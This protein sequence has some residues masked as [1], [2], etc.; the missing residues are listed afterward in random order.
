MSA[1][2]EEALAILKQIPQGVDIKSVESDGNDNATFTNWTDTSHSA[3]MKSWQANKKGP[4]LWTACGGFAANFA[5]RLGIT[6]IASIFELEQSL[7][8]LDKAY[9]WVSASSGAK[10]QVGDILRHT[11]YHVD[12]AAGW[13]GDALLRVAAGQSHHKRP[14]EDPSAEFDVL[15]WVG[16][17]S[18]YV[19]A[20]FR[21]WLDLDLYFAGAP[22]AEGWLRGWW[23]VKEDWNGNTYYYY[24]GADNVVKYTETKPAANSGPPKTAKNTGRY[25]YTEPKQLVLTWKTV[26]GAEAACRETFYN[27]APACRLMNAVSNLYGPLVATRLS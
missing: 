13:K 19:A 7:K 1:K 16:G 22:G 9:A 21:G 20:N 5:K 15:K 25:T 2:R 8:D 6:G 26:P 23:K 3:M 10:P 24:F 17:E 14:T 4:V 27:A 11:K 18:D 12:V